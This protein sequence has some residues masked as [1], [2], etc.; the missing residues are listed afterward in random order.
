M[1][2]FLSNAD[3]EL[4]ALGSIVHR[5]PAGFPAVRAANP[6]RLD[7]APDLDGVRAVVVRLL[8]GRTAWEPA[9]DELRAACLAA[10]V[11]L[12]ALGG[13]AEPDAELTRLSTVPAGTAREAHRYLAAGGPPNVEHLLRFVADTVLLDGFG[14]DPPRPLPLTEVWDGAGLGAPGAPAR[15]R[16][17]AGGRRVL[18]GPPGGGEHAVRGRP[19]P[20]D[21]GRRRRRAAGV[22]LLAA[23]RRR[24]AGRGAGAAARP[25]GRGA[26]DDGAG[27]GPLRG[28]ERRRGR[29]L[30]GP[31]ARRPGRAG[32]PGPR[33]QPVPRRL[34]RR[35]GGADAARRGHG[36]GDPRVRRAHHR[37]RVRL[38]GG[39]RRRGRAGHAG[40]RQPH[41]P[42]AGG[43]GCR[44]GGAPRPPAPHPARRQAGRGGDVG[45][46]DEAQPARQR[47]RPRHACVGD[48]AAPR[49]AGRRLPG[50]PHPRR[51]RRPDGRAGRPLHL[52]EPPAHRRPGP[53]GRRPPPG[54]RVHRLVRATR[55]RSSGR[56]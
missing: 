49:P 53:G 33:L 47:R 25:R 28:H 6:G 31:A 34:D 44:A 46:P 54:R 38:Q 14:F 55:P 41:R 19:L 18:P 51:R 48:R 21:R 52:R 26:G 15:S 42:R 5:L 37:P 11:P 30:A 2:L 29:R 40:D 43:P 39:G 23:P 20:G 16:A 4:L 1:I 13:E 24:R 9:F 10:E 32:H 12:V 50:R 7:A 22:V 17:A 35:R 36:G 56:R 3:T 45:V 8:G 27:H